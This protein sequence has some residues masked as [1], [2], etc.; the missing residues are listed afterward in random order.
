MSTILK[1]TG[2]TKYFP[3]AKKSFF[4]KTETVQAVDDVSFEIGAGEAVGLVGESG[5]GKSTT[6]RLIT[7][8]I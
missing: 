1:I 4:G 2:L 5:C 8:L 6:G 7:R 3:I